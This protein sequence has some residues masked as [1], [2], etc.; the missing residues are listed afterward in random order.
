MEGAL[1]RFPLSEIAQN[2]D[3]CDLAKIGP[4][5]TAGRPLDFGSLPNPFIVFGCRGPK[6]LEMGSSWLR[7]LNSAV[8]G[9]FCPS[10]FSFF[11]LGRIAGPVAVLQFL[12]MFK[13]HNKP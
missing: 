9:N 10:F 11:R 4:I 7:G 12:L 13:E 3:K 5:P 6:L 2:D 1:A 8:F